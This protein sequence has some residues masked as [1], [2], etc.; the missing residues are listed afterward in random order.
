MC[1]PTKPFEAILGRLVQSSTLCA[2]PRLAEQKN[3]GPLLERLEDSLLTLTAELA[4]VP[5]AL[6]D[7][8]PLRPGD[9]VDTQLHRTSEVS[10]RLEGRS[11]FRGQAVIHEGRRAVRIT[12]F[13]NSP[14]SG[15]APPPN[16]ARSMTHDD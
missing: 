15:V 10:V 13:V 7:L 3:R 12:G 16:D 9:T 5:I 2:T 1:L 6:E 4:P 14:Q 11:V 8:L